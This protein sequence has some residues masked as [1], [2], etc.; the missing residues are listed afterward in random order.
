MHAD[1]TL[2]VSE[3]C[4][5]SVRPSDSP[6]KCFLLWLSLVLLFL[7]ETESLHSKLDFLELGLVCAVIEFAHFPQPGLI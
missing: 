1:Q 3:L 7:A 6:L 2:P 4:L 5:C